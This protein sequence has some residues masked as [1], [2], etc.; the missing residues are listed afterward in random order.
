MNIERWHCLLAIL[1][2]ILIEFLK[3][4]CHLREHSEWSWQSFHSGS[5]NDLRKLLS[6]CQ[7]WVYLE[8]SHQSSWTLRF[9]WRRQGCSCLIKYTGNCYW[10]GANANCQVRLHP[11]ASY[12]YALSFSNISHWCC[13]CTRRRETPLSCNHWTLF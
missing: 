8:L 5:I 13:C 10:I 6:V 1:S 11:I 12:D 2:P 3:F 4:S 9:L 7:Q